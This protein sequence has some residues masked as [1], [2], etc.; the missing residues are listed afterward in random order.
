MIDKYEKV[1]E[2]NSF[3]FNAPLIVLITFVIL[4]LYWGSAFSF[5]IISLLFGSILPFS[6]LAYML[7]KGS[8]SDIFASTRKTRI[9]PLVVTLMNI[10]MG[11]IFLEILNAPEIFITFMICLFIN[12]FLIMIITEEWKISI[13]TASI[14]FPATFLVY[15]LGAG[16]IPFFLLILPIAWA[17]IKLR[18]HN[19]NQVVAGSLLTICLTMVQLQLIK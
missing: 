6:F 2:A 9:I 19:L 11:I 12:T 4:Q 18:A 7:K 3:V 16:M 10:L 5:L 1:A 13:H 15:K 14:T 17:R 8:V